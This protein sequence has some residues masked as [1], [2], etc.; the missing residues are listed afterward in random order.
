MRSTLA[1]QLRNANQ[2]F[3]TAKEQ[4]DEEREIRADLQRQLTKSSGEA[5]LWRSKYEQ[6]GLARA[7]ELEEAKRKL[8][9]KLDEA[10]EQVDEALTKC[11]GLEKTKQRLQVEVED[12][13]V[14][15]ERANANAT[16]MEKRQKQ[17]DKLI[18]EWKQKCEDISVELE[19]SQREARLYSSELFKARAQYEE[20]LEGNEALRR[21]NKN[22]A[23]EIRDL[24]E[25][26]GE[27][28]KTAHEWERS[29]KRLEMEKEEMQ[30]ALE[31]SEGQLEQEAAR[32]LKMQLELGQARHEIDRKLA[33]KEEEFEALRA[34]HQR[35]LES[36]QVSLAAESRGKAEAIRQKK[37]LEGDINELEI[38]LDHANRMHADSLKSVKRLSLTIDELQSQ[39]EEERRQRDE[40][41]EAGLEAERKW[42]VAVEEMEGVRSALEVSERARRLAEGELHEAADKIAELSAVN[43]A[44]VGVKRKMEMDE[45]ALAG[46]LEEAVVELKLSEERVRKASDDASRLSEELR[47]EQ[48]GLIVCLVEGLVE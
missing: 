15:V 12:L 10:E 13:M 29:C 32:V 24:I 9:A 1:Q 5:V 21:E 35:A 3:L 2:D 20:C 39:V 14:D 43:A 41:R 42:A 46:D 45:V 19:M 47:N 11:A 38:G 4:A 44:L 27:G 6:E 17:F 40:A 23:D 7:E 8:A 18:Q 26:L 36:V 28:G 48:V 31:E 30:A 22:L 16:S 25:Q 33:D 37:K 34:N